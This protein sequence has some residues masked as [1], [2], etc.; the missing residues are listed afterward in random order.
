MLKIM[1]M[2]FLQLIRQPIWPT[3]FILFIIVAIFLPRAN[4]TDLTVIPGMVY[5]IMVMTLL[6]FIYGAERARLEIN[7]QFDETISVTPLFRKYNRSTLLYWLVLSLLIYIVFYLAIV[8][9]IGIVHRSITVGGVLE[10]FTYTLFCWFIPFFSSIILGYVIYS[11]LPNIYSYLM[12]IGVWFLTMPYNSMVGILPR[13]WGGWLINGDPNIIEINSVSFLESLVINNGYYIQRIFMFLIVMALYLW[14]RYKRNLKIKIF[15]ISLLAVSML[16]PIFSP[17]VPYITGKGSLDSATTLSLTE[18]QSVTV[19]EEY[20][21]NKYTFNFKH[22]A[23]N[24]D[25]KYRVAMDITSNTDHIT[26]ALLQD[27]KINTVTMSTSPVKMK[28]LGQLVQLEL[29]ERNGTIEMEIETSTYSPI[30]PTTAQLVATSAWYPMLPSEAQDPYH[31]GVKEDYELYW[32][33]PMPHPILSNLDENNVNH[34]VGKAYG[35]TILMGKFDKI[36]NLTFPSYKL[37]QQ[38]EPLTH[39]INEVMQKNNQ[40]YNVSEKLPTHL[41]YAP[42]FNGIQ[43]NPDEV[44]INPES[45]STSD[46]FNAFYRGEGN[47]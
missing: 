11:W 7:Q 3:I 13:E 37:L 27:F 24:H 15:S 18:E 29:P 20:Q 31:H 16:V 43:A 47:Q 8:G 34:W 45:Y 17:Y 14:T 26:L 35:P 40:E 6:L 33:S 22:G 5:F 36:D 10:S 21:I 2:E 9:Y 38:I 30:G 32:D 19:S 23:S 46:I 25:L 4:I 41:Y 12:I 1:K 42:V 39:T 28:R 44:Y